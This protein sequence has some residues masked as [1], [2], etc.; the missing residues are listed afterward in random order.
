MKLP[1]HLP[2]QLLKLINNKSL[3]FFIF[4]GMTSTLLWLLG[5]PTLNVLMY[6]RSGIASGELWRVLSG[7]IVHSNGWHLL[8]NLASLLMI[9]LL[10]SQ[11]L[12]RLFWLLVFTLS[13]LMISACYFWIAPEYEYY[14]GLS[15][16]LYA[17]IIIG[18]LLDIKE[19][20]L[21]AVIV[22]VVVTARVIWQQYSGSMDSLAELIE[23]R[24]AIESHLFGICT[25]Y[26]IGLT[27]ML[28]QRYLSR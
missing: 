15:A 22:L 6:H 18:A 4:T 2:S 17:V 11:H 25:G 24:V 23:D 28:R 9:G 21:I 14:V 1:S 13:G 19:Q 12:T 20:P 7:H 10:F 5:E 16:V 26:V 3:L 8:L 27:L